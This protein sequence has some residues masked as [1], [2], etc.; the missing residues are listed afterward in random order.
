MRPPDPERAAAPAD[1]GAEVKATGEVDTQPTQGVCVVACSPATCS[2]VCPFVRIADAVEAIAA[3]IT[4][5]PPR[6][7]PTER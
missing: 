5:R 2:T 7:W 1:T 6:R 3:A 4:P